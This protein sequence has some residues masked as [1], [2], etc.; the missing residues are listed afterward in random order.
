[1]AESAGKHVFNT[2]QPGAWFGRSGFIPSD[3]R[4][5]LGPEQSFRIGIKHD[6]IVPSFRLVHCIV[7]WSRGIERSGHY[8]HFTLDI[9]HGKKLHVHII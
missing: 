9:T 6:T 5:S 3:N 8:L 7:N 2:T 4:L 1:M